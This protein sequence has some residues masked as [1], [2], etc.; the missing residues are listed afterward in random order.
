MIDNNVE[1]MRVCVSLS[2]VVEESDTIVVTASDEGVVEEWERPR[3]VIHGHDKILNR[4]CMLAL[5]RLPMMNHITSSI[6]FSY[7]IFIIQSPL[8]HLFHESS[9]V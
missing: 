6:L 7:C 5:A 8:L 9:V 4:Q 2:L 3:M 1:M